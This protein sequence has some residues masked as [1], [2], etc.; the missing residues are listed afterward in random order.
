MKISLV[1][2]IIA[3]LRVEVLDLRT[4]CNS[5]A[6]FVDAVTEE[7]GHATNERT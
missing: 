4:G 3:L 6:P 7:R 2:L 1:S 5:V